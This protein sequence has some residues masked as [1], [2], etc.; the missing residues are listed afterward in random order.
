MRR[1]VNAR[2]PPSVGPPL[3]PNENEKNMQL[4]VQLS[5]SLMGLINN[6]A[7]T[8]CPQFCMFWP[9]SAVGPCLG[10]RRRQRPQKLKKREVDVFAEASPKPR[11][12]LAEASLKPRRNLAEASPKPHR[13][14]PGQYRISFIQNYGQ[15]ITL[16]IQQFVHGGGA[17]RHCIH[18]QNSLDKNK[19]YD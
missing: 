12:S 14:G 4:T 3:Q 16:D 5:G 9:L 2:N 6:I 11:R 18:L 10:R 8:A 15:S 7:L 17:K 13:R 1:C 19:M